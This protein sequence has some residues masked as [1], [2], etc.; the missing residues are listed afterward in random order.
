[1][2][3]NRNKLRHFRSWHKK[4]FLHLQNVLYEGTNTKLKLKSKQIFSY[5]KFTC[6]QSCFDKRFLSVYG[7]FGL[8]LY[9]GEGKW[10]L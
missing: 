3:Q 5:K 9:Y 2:G 10:K 8:F 1:M 7:R 6:K 4:S